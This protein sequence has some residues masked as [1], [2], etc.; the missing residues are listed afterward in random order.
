[1]FLTSV[2]MI[3]KIRMLTNIAN[4]FCWIDISDPLLS[5]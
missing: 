5:N 4:T 2:M 3:T 1:L